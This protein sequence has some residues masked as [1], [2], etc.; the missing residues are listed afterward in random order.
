MR[1]AGIDRQALIIVGDVLA[2][3]REGLKARSLLYD[4]DFAHGFRGHD[5]LMRIAVV[6]ITRNGA[7]LGKRLGRVWRS[8]AV[9]VSSRYAGQA[10]K[11]WMIFE[12]AE[13][14][15]LTAVRSGRSVDGFVLI[16]ATGIVVRMIAPLLESKRATRPW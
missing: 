13:L 8:G 4:G 9:H 11:G 3:R 16:M 2:A 1:E 12:P 14:K 15:G 10:G 5:G 6:A 7:L